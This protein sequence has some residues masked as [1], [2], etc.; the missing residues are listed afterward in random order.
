MLVTTLQTGD[1]KA[2]SESMPKTLAKA[3]EQ[4]PICEIEKITGRGQ[5]VRYIEFELIKMTTLISVSGNLNNTQVQFIATQMV[6]MFPN[7]SLVDFKLCFER[8]CI[9]QYGEI[10]RM[11][12]IVLRGWMEK[13]LDEKYQ[14][15]EDK[16]MK[17]KDSI[18]GVRP[19]QATNE[20]DW[21]KIWLESI[22]VG[23]RVPGMTDDEIKRN[24]QKD[25]PR[26]ESITKG[27][28]YHNVRGVE[29]YAMDQQHAE[30]I[31]KIM[32]RDGTLEE[33]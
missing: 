20:K 21:H 3:T 29:I 13:Y 8:G 19:T 2:L 7:E 32:I 28:R 24:G 31:V 16:L 1:F 26:K 33:Y 15:V 9:G 11:D 5:V 18:Y 14:V 4:P 6:E 25:T 17:E 12:G 10:Y 27:Y 23:N 22:G 30:E